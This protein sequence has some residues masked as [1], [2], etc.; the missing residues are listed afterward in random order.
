MKRK[1]IPFNIELMNQTEKSI[2]GMKQITSLDTWERSTK[3]F[4][5]DG[6]YSTLAFGVA[7]TEIRNQRFGYIDLH[8]EIL[9][10]LIVI[11][12]G[13]MRAL[14]LDIMSGKAFAVWNPETNDFD[15]S[16]ALE[17]QT[18]YAF[19][20]EYWKRII[21]EKRSSLKRQELIDLVEN[22]KDT[23]SIRYHLVIP[24][25]LRDME[26][27]ES[28]RE[29]SDEINSLYYKLIAISNTI[30]VTT[31]KVSPEAYNRQRMALQHTAGEIFDTLT[32]IIDGKKGL[33]SGKWAAR[34]LFDGTRNVI[35]SM[36]TTVPVLGA[37]GYPG[38]NDSTMGLY[39]ALKGTR[40]VSVFLIRN[41]FLNKVFSAPGAPAKLVNRKTLQTEYGDLRSEDYDRWMTIEGIEKQFS[42]YAETS[43][44]DIPIVIGGRY[45]GLVYK[46]TN[47]TFKLFGGLDELPKGMDPKLCT[48][49]TLTILFYASVYFK[50]NDYPAIVTRY[51]VT[52]AGSL[53]ESKLSL[54]TTIK[55]EKRFELDDDWKIMTDHIA[56][57]FPVV[58]SAHYNSLSCH[59][60]RLAGLGADFD[61][62]STFN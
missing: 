46:G 57:Q 52:G 60:S 25:G 6:L 33:V 7:G 18:G 31:A 11:A 32:M 9:H 28:G 36:N 55:A 3:N 40:S 14:Y 38:F 4:H 22:R 23:C 47:G 1:D 5:P 42:Y 50:L 27:D 8:L 15:V 39:Q 24:A 29:S 12:L 19:F 44:R 54:K 16:N 10:P 43:V 34:G 37:S 45:L 30:N 49:I 62:D 41:G 48:P 2:I 21:F 53:V 35:T 20:I 51:P 17:G 58:G 26:I 61:G 59:P 13:K 56:Y